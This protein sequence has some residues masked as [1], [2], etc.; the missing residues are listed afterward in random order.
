MRYKGN[1]KKDWDVTKPE[2]KHLEILKN[3][4]KITTK[5]STLSSMDDDNEECVEAIPPTKRGR[6]N[7]EILSIA[8]NVL[9]SFLNRIEKPVQNSTSNINIVPPSV[10]ASSTSLFSESLAHDLNLLIS[11]HFA[12]AKMRI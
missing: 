8:K 6:V 2:I 1:T 9:V 10:P 7:D 11:R 5:R 4:D 3:Y 12:S